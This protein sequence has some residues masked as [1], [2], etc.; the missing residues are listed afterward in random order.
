MTM[1]NTQMPHQTAKSNEEHKCRTQMS[2]NIANNQ[3][4]YSE[5]PECSECSQNSEYS[6]YSGCDSK[7]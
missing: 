2:T 3:T 6:K 7:Y 1:K 4:K 5:Y